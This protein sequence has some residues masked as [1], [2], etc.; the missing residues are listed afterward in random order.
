MCRV[1]WFPSPVTHCFND[2]LCLLEVD[3]AS[4]AGGQKTLIDFGSGV[5]HRFR[6]HFT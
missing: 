4:F 3:S 2:E 5:S 6:K 1:A